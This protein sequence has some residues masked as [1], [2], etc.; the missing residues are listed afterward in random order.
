MANERKDFSPP[1]LAPKLLPTL[2]SRSA[3]KLM[4]TLRSGSAANRGP[5]EQF[6]PPGC[7]NARFTQ[8]APLL[9]LAGAPRATNLAGAPVRT[10]IAGGG[11]KPLS[12]HSARE[13]CLPAHGELLQLPRILVM[14][15]G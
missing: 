12:P 15:S 11:P 5:G 9:D 13:W 14:A 8:H 1:L 4:P 2:R 7:L 10:H 6:T 3:V